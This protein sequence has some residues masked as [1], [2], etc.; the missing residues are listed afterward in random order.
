MPGVTVGD[1]CVIGA[2]S[3]ILKNTV[4]PDYTIWAGVPARQIRKRFTDDK[5][6]KLKEIKWWD[7]SDEAICNAIPI[8]QSNDIHQLI[9]YYENNI[10]SK[11]MNK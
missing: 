8:L 7:W 10:K 3:L 5:V 4:I 9:E 6:K 2:N 11:S 1:G